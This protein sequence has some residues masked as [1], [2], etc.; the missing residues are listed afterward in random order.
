MAGA[1]CTA[2]A[3][4][5]AAR[6]D[7]GAHARARC[8]RSAWARR[9]RPPGCASC[10][11][12]SSSRRRPARAAAVRRRGRGVHACFAVSR[13]RCS[14]VA[15][16]WRLL[17][18]RWWRGQRSACTSGWTG[19]RDRQVPVCAWTTSTASGSDAHPRVWCARAATRSPAPNWAA[20]GPRKGRPQ[21]EVP[22]HHPQ[23]MLSRAG[24]TL[25]GCGRNLLARGR[26]GAA[27]SSGGA[28]APKP[29]NTAARV[30]WQRPA[31]ER[32]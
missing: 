24:R 14:R 26:K 27:S 18:R 22:P 19:A 5:G 28:S 3:R 6:R 21:A 16:S 13:Q 15:C 7:F 17:S 10:S 29:A 20:L 1:F 32:R 4:R 8:S 2:A 31:G 25:S 12:L 9:V 30:P 23:T 11:V